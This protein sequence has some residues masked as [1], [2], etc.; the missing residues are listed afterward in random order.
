[1]TSLHANSTARTLRLA[2]VLPLAL[3]TTF[4]A[5]RTAIRPSTD[6]PTRIDVAQLW[7]EPSNLAARDLFYGAGGKELAPDASTPY[8]L[9]AVDT[10]GFSAGYDVRDRQGTAWSVKL[11]IEA[12]PE[13][14]ASRI[15]WA[16]GFH[17]PATYLLPQWQLSGAQA[18]TDAGPKPVA[19]FR[20]EPAD[21]KVVAEWSWYENPFVNTQPFKGLIVANLLLNNW[22]WKTSNN[23]I[24]DV[25]DAQGTGYRMYVV[26]DLGAS[27]GKTTFPQLLTRTPLRAMAQ[28][29]RNDVAGFEEQGF[30]KSVDGQHVS[31]DYR[32]IHGRLVDTVTIDDVVW[33]CRLMSQLS[34]QQWREAFRAAGYS[35]ADQQRFISKMRT[36]IQNGLAL[37][38]S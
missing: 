18:G 29:S 12:Q 32:G 34:D 2:G 36:K 24:Y 13:I 22:D 3:L 27:L 6:D 11:G 1:M 35:D 38:K 25:V 4:C 33:T 19:R 9:V 7:A 21:H 16:I 30:I 31:F 28:G 23:K 20:R 15:L 14:V 5:G 10:T 17:Q 26:R 8:E 37:A